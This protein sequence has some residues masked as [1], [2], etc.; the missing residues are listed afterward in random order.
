MCLEWIAPQP[1]ASAEVRNLCISSCAEASR[2]LLACSW[3]SRLVSSR[4]VPIAFL[5]VCAAS[6]NKS[7][8]I[9]VVCLCLLCVLEVSLKLS[10]YFREA[11]QR[12]S[13]G[14]IH[15]LLFS[16]PAPR[17]TYALSA[18]HWAASGQRHLFHL[19]LSCILFKNDHNDSI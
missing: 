7:A 17:T 9:S 4:L 2:R 10:L 19:P 8:W 14:N 12:T 13:H 11:W 5:W 3:S 16:T 6:S 1:S 15:F 18:H